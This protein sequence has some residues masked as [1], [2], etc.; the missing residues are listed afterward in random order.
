MGRCVDFILI[1]IPVEI[2]GENV[3][4]DPGAR[5]IFVKERFT[6]RNFEGFE[7]AGMNT[8]VEER[9][10]TQYHAQQCLKLVRPPHVHDVLTSAKDFYPT[11]PMSRRRRA[12]VYDVKRWVPEAGARAVSSAYISIGKCPGPFWNTTICC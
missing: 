2:T 7:S 10:S 6:L 3:D 8:S 9:C 5:S 4:D 1:I 11:L 12:R